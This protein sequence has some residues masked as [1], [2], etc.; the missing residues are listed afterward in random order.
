MFNNYFHV[1]SLLAN[2]NIKFIFTSLSSTDKNTE[3][4]RS[5]IVTDV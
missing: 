2:T 5:D 3:I 4:I 1:T